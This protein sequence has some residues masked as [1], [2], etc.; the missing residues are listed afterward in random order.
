MAEAEA[1]LSKPN[2]VVGLRWLNLHHRNLY[3]KITNLYY[4][5]FE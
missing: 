3:Y 4:K 1:Y 5:T 2:I